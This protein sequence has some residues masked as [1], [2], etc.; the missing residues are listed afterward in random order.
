MKS[1]GKTFCLIWID[2][3]FT[4]WLLEKQYNNNFPYVWIQNNLSVLTASVVMKLHCF[5]DNC[6]YSGLIYFCKY[7][8]CKI[9]TN[10]HAVSSNREKFPVKYW[11]ATF[12]YVS[13][14]V[15]IDTIH[16]RHVIFLFFILDTSSVIRFAT[17]EFK[18]RY[19]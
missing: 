4:T 7:F 14:W 6:N 15:V 1:S 9:I 19:F 16:R 10:K 3:T 5:P 17:L 13:F 2:I 8:L 18:I 11:K 12:I